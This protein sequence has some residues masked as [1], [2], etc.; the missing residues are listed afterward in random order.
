MKSLELGKNTSQAEVQ[1]ISKFG[2]WLF[3]KGKEYFL[4]FKAY[5]WFK[6]ARISQVQNVKLLHNVHLHWP[7]LDIDL[8]INSLS[9]P[10][11]Y[12]LVYR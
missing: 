10:E 2:I 12:P 5:P 6:N 3:V 7:D 1:D 4:P 11:S 9:N 8:E